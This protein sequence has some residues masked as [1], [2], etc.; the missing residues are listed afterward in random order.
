MKSKNN[1][2]NNFQRNL[3]KSPRCDGCELECNV[4]Y[5]SHHDQYFSEACGL[6]IMEMG[7]YLIPYGDIWGEDFIY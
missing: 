2:L 3:I 7:I 1:Q 4:L 6:V 5:D